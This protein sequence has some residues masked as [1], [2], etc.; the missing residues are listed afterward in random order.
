MAISDQMIMI[1]TR[2][3]YA[4]PGKASGFFLEWNLEQ[5]GAALW[6][7]KV[8]KDQKLKGKSTMIGWE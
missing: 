3:K 8:E 7:P 1:L 2:K 4:V 6:G 5:M